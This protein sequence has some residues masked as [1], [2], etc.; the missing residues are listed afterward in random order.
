VGQVPDL[1]SVEFLVDVAAK[2]TDGKDRR[3]YEET[4]R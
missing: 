3:R 1:P 4:P 2:N